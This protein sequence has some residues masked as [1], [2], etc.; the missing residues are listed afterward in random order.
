[1]GPESDFKTPGQ[2]ISSLLAQ[3]GWTK[4]TLAIVLGM[5]ETIVNRLISDKRSMD[6]GTALSLE[7]VFNVPADRFMDLQKRF[8]L[9]SARVVARPDPGRATRAHIFGGLPIAEMIKRGW[10]DASSAKDVP[11]VEAA[12]AKFFGV[13]SIDEVEI[14]P[15]AAKRTLVNTEPSAAQLAWLYRIRE[16]A[17]EM[18]VAPFSAGAL[19]AALPKLKALLAAPEEARKVPR[20]LAEAGVRFV[21]VETLPGAKIDGVCFWLADNAPVI[22][23][24]MRHD[25]ID[26]FWF[27]LRHEIEHVLEGHG[28]LAA[29][30]DAD[31]EGVGAGVGLE[32]PEEERVANLAAAEFAIPTKMMDAFIARKNPFFAERDI[33]GFAA[34]MGVHPGLVAGQLQHRT[35]RYDRFRNHL[36]KVRSFVTPSAIVDGWGDV[37]PTGL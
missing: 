28:K 26:N 37:A 8:E 34:T 17:S 24:T 20:I 15:H 13:G 30:L 35:G 14:L 19:R 1:M 3:R 11:G 29:I 16:I 33:L 2:L 12:V 7:E 4:R 31:L 36:V 21:I 23:L 9:A 32:I 22:G 5:E 18:L 27:V 10:L 6:G 25:R